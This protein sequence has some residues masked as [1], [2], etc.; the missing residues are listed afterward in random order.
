MLNGFVPD[1]FAYD[2]DKGKKNNQDAIEEA[3]ELEALAIEKGKQLGRAERE[4]EIVG[5]SDKAQK[6]GKEAE[7][8]RI[9]YDLEELWINGKLMISNEMHY[10]ILCSIK[11]IANKQ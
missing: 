8:A 7:R 6:D 9:I 4:K 3:E 2:A 1:H 10:L 11:Q 5:E